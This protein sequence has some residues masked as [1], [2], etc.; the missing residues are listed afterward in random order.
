MKLWSVRLLTKAI[1]C[2]SG[3]HTGFPFVPQILTNGFSPL[4]MSVVR[5]PGATG[6]R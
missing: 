5:G 6:T 1:L 3:D 2:P 4:S